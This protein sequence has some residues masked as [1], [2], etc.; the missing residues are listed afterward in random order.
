MSK[1]SRKQTA[2]TYRA[3]EYVRSHAASLGLFLS[4][5]GAFYLF[6]VLLG[7]WT[8]VDWGKD[9]TIYPSLFV[10]TLIPRSVISPAFFVTSFPALVFGAAILCFY[11]IRGITPKAAPDKQYVAIVLT[12]FGFTYLVIGDWPLKLPEFPWLWQSQIAA[13]GPVFS[14]IL[15]LLGLGALLVGAFSLYKH[16][17]IYHQTHQNE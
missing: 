15:Y 13:N 9:V 5:Y 1:S 10:N 2:Y 3:S 11:S 16:S 4:V 17:L 12:I 8:M 7:G 6:V 14:W